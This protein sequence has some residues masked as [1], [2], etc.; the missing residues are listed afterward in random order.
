MTFN[1]H[2][3]VFVGFSYLVACALLC[4]L[5]GAYLYYFSLDGSLVCFEAD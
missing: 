4:F 3:M 2:S 1:T 5:K